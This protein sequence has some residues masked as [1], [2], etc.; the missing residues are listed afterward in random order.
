M[1]VHVLG[2]IAQA[3]DCTNIESVLSFNSFEDLTETIMLNVC[4]NTAINTSFIWSEVPESTDFDASETYTTF[5]H[6]EYVESESAELTGIN[7]NE[8]EF[9]SSEYMTYTQEPQVASTNDKNFDSSYITIDATTLES[10]LELSTAELASITS[11]ALTN[12]S[13]DTTVELILSTEDLIS[14]SSDFST[15]I[16]DTS[17]I[18]STVELI[19]EISDFSTTVLETSQIS[20]TVELISEISDFSTTVLETSQISSTVEL[21]SESSDF[22]TTFLETSQTYSTSASS[23]E[24]SE[25]ETSAYEDIFSIM[26]SESTYSHLFSSIYTVQN[27]FE[28]ITRSTI[29]TDE[30][31]SNLVGVSLYFTAE[32]NKSKFTTIT[33]PALDYLTSVSNSDMYESS[34][35]LSENAKPSTLSLSSKTVTWNSISQQI[36]TESYIDIYSE[37]STKSMLSNSIESLGTKRDSIY[38]TLSMLETPIESDKTSAFASSRRLI[39][40]ESGNIAT[41]SSHTV[42]AALSSGHVIVNTVTPV[43]TVSLAQSLAKTVLR[44]DEEN[45][46]QYYI[47]TVSASDHSQIVSSSTA[48]EQSATTTT[49]NNPDVNSLLSTPGGITGLVIIIIVI[50]LLVAALFYKLFTSGKKNRIALLDEEISD[51]GEES[52]MANRALSPVSPN[53]QTGFTTSG[54]SKNIEPQSPQQK[55]SSLVIESLGASNLFKQKNRKKSDAAALEYT[56]PPRRESVNSAVRNK[57]M[58]EQFNANAFLNVVR[59]LDKR[60]FLINLDSISISK[61]HI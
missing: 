54:L 28:S 26:Q 14:E 42:A 38:I 39:I 48:T 49:P 24:T 46:I 10:S 3:T 13:S 2:A 7:T 60:V 29:A 34:S 52:T 4:Q 20:S 50:L 37:F 44:S 30:Y 5:G 56:A 35:Y 58:E 15:T 40:L 1:L 55:Q 18:S 6:T 57:M 16:L 59:E 27:V 17:Q 9:L 32:G 51:Y 45:I 21:I 41:S 25:N 47:S 33:Q 12:L 11:T 53:N 8:T 19:S 43:A 36:D 61:C 23:T 31:G 22:S